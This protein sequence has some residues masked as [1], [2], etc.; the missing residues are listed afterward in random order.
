MDALIL[1]LLVL[2]VGSLA[3]LQCA[4]ATGPRV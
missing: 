2:A 3:G 1:A 4:T